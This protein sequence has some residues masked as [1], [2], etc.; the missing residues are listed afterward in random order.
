M[1]TVGDAMDMLMVTAHPDPGS[2][3]H[4]VSAAAKAGQTWPPTGERSCSTTAAKIPAAIPIAGK[5]AARATSVTETRRRSR[6]S[7][8]ARAAATIR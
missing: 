2:F 6:Q 1:T 4:A 5:S 7:V 3:C 8:G